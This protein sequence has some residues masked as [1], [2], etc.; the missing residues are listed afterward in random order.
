M[1]SQRTRQS[2]YN[3]CFTKLKKGRL[4]KPLMISS[5]LAPPGSPAT[6]SVST[7]TEVSSHI[8]KPA[9]GLCYLCSRAENVFLCFP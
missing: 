2:E 4:S 3:I 1:S 6:L 5:S 8:M 9:S 7:I